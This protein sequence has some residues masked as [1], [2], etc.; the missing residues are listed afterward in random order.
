MEISP[1]WI[2]KS[3]ETDQNPILSAAIAT[4]GKIGT[5]KSEAFLASLAGSKAPQAEP[6]QIALDNIRLR[7]ARQPASAPTIA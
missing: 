5:P 7:Y 2:K 6:A 1:S 4:L 3:G